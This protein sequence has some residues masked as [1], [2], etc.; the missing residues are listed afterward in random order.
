MN[1]STCLLLLAPCYFLVGAALGVFMAATGD[2]RAVAVHAHVNLLGWVTL[3]IIGILYRIF[4][5][6]SRTPLAKAQF[7]LHNI[8]LPIAM[9][10]LF[11]F[12]RGH[13]ELKPVL[14]AGM[15]AMIA[16]F[17]CLT[18]NLVKR[19]PRGQ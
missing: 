3:A 4:P 8:G 15:L 19:L 16:G 9:V 13:E 7:W 6:L 11:F 17:I 18:I 5:D 10:A 12:R 14:G 2:F 1:L